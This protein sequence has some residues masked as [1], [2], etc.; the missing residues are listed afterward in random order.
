MNGYWQYRCAGT[1]WQRRW[2]AGSICAPVW[3]TIGRCG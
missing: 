2:C 1:T 3:T